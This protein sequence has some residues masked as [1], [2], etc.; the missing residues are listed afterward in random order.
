VARRSYGQYCGL[1]R[2]VDMVGERWALLIIRDLFVGPR[3]FTDLRN[4]LPRIP[5]NI[6]SA[7]LRELEAAGVVHRRVLP[8]PSGSMVYE[9]T[10][11]GRE[12][13]GVVLALGRWGAKA[14]GEP[15]P[16]EIITCDS[17][18][19]AMRSLFRAEEAADVAVAYELRLG[20]VV[21]GV[22][23]DKGGLDVTEG[24]LEGA[25]LV[26][27]TGPAIRAL[28][29]GE[30]APGAAIADGTVHVT[31]DPA[32]LTTFTTLFRI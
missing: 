12:L 5:T 8:R 17:I 7:R 25:D 24:G 13:E 11:Y 29:A 16:G 6:L 9:L 10:A 26:I 30:I 32:L 19:I 22:R 20:D 23:V 15:K 14:L 27:E 4:G 31:G 18:T 1:V 28:L 2:A 3:R 21:L